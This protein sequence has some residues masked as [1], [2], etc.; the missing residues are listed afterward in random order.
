M[1][2]PELIRHI[3]KNTDSHLLYK[4]H[5]IMSNDYLSVTYAKKYLKLLFD[6]TKM[7]VQLN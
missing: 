4:N 7:K 6:C 3:R 5:T 2:L 1:W